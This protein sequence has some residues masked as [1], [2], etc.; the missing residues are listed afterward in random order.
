MATLPKVS[1]H[2]RAAFAIAS[3]SLRRYVVAPPPALGSGIVHGRSVSTFSRMPA[4]LANPTN[5]SLEA[6][7]GIVAFNDALTRSEGGVVNHTTAPLWP[8]V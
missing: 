3:P 6:L 2:F 4:D 1:A 7:R 5:A 8:I